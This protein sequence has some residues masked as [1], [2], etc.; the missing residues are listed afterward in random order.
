MRILDIGGPW[1]ED[2]HQGLEFDAPAVTLTEGMAAQYQALFGDRLRLPL[3]HHASRAIVGAA[4]PLAHP[5]LAINVA[6]GQSTWA[7]QRV[8]A[9]LFYRGL[10]LQRPVLLGD[11]LHTRTRVVG[12]RQNAAKAGRAATGIVALEMAT[13]NQR[14]ETVLHFWR[15]PMIPC[16]DPAADTGHA[17]D[18]DAIGRATDEAALQAAVPRGWSLGPA[19]RWLGR[20]AADLRPGDV[21]RIESRDTVTS[22][23]ELVRTSLNMAMAHTD[24][25]FSYLGERLVYGGHTIFMSFAQV[26][27]ALPNLLTLLAWESCDHTAPVVES[28]RLRTEF[29]VTDIR[30]A[31]RDAGGALLRLH[32][33]CFAARGP[34]VPGSPEP[35]S[36]VLD[37]KFWAWSP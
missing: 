3:D 5:L 26:T 14:G 9:N 32:V 27:R 4:M 11:T 28:D 24:A 22:A 29:T 17:D 19:G 35:E 16:R 8:K 37:W 2:F 18:L 25:R 23:P 7:S 34:I 15:C 12:L 1:F 21:F 6:I 13:T 30:P 36:L 33:T 31:P 20:C 10:V